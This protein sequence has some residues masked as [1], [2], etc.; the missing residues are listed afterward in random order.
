MF[1]IIIIAVVIGGD[2]PTT[3]FAIY[4][5]KLYNNECLARRQCVVFMIVW[6]PTCL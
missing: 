4:K 2:P 1:I 6:L 3:F 5:P